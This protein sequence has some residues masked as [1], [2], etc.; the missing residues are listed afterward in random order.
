MRDALSFVSTKGEWWA[1][2]GM[3]AGAFVMQLTST[4]CALVALTAYFLGPRLA[5][6]LALTFTEMR[7]VNSNAVRAV[8]AVA[9][10]LT[11][12]VSALGTL[13]LYVSLQVIRSPL[14]LWQRFSRR[15]S[16]SQ[17]VLEASSLKTRAA[18]APTRAEA[19]ELMAE[20]LLRNE[21]ERRVLRPKVA[22]RTSEVQEEH[23]R[24]EV[25]EGVEEAEEAE[26]VDD[27]D[28]ALPISNLAEPK[29][30]RVGRTTQHAE[31]TSTTSRG[32][33]A[34]ATDPDGAAEGWQRK[35]LRRRGR[36]SASEA[37]HGV[38]ESAVVCARAFTSQPHAVPQTSSS[39]EV[40][41]H[42]AHPANAPWSF[43]GAPWGFKVPP[44]EGS[45][46]LGSRAGLGLGGSTDARLRDDLD[47]FTAIEIVSSQLSCVQ[48]EVRA[49][50]AEQAAL[51]VAV[52]DI[53]NCLRHGAGDDLQAGG[54]IPAE[55]KPATSFSDC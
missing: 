29:S 37:V 19:A 10:R 9:F 21:S 15:K 23:Q 27:V 41:E 38:D 14:M 25:E 51:R 52:A 30:L 35:E 40:E 7:N 4:V 5:Q 1:L 47:A 44:S 53:L 43:D 18:A 26:E 49:L 32:A 46:S 50:A 24:E 22:D 17:R 20:A 48:M 2:G 45:G 3:V 55:P 16:G 54:R 13:L 42:D 36:R 12:T 39:S 28:E 6:R 8:P 34:A 11:E 33:S 31:G